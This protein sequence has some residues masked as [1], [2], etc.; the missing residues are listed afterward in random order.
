MAALS[1]GPGPVAALLDGLEDIGVANHN[2]PDQ[3]V[4]S[5][6]RA[7][8]AEAVRR[9]KSAG[10][11]A[12]MLPVARA[13]HSPLVASARGPLADLATRV[14]IEPPRRPVY[15]NVTAAPY[16]DVAAAIAAQVGDHLACPV[17]FAEMVE[18]MHDD[19]ARVFVEAGPGSRLT[20]LV[21]AILGWPPPPGRVVRP[22]RPS[23]PA[24]A[25]CMRWRGC[26]SRA[27]RCLWT[28]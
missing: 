18:S 17:R 19:G 10:I 15:S 4:I 12:Q 9:A 1:A 8:V 5:G 3:T 24:R 7:A 13:F 21:G 11:R 16:P 26:S 27:S 23:R 25:L 28:A 2:G 20:G 6:A 14:G 22:L